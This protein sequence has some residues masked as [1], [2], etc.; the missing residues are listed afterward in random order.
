MKKTKNNI[1]KKSLTTKKAFKFR[2]NLTKEQEN[3]L[4]E[5]IYRC[6]K[7][8]NKGINKITSNYQIAKQ[9]Y[10][11]QIISLYT[12]R[13]GNWY[14]IFSDSSIIKKSIKVK[15]WQPLIIKD[16]SNIQSYFNYQSIIPPF[17]QTPESIELRKNND[18]K[19]LKYKEDLTIKYP[20]IPSEFYPNG[21]PLR[22]GKIKSVEKGGNNLPM[23]RL[24]QNERETNKVIHINLPAICCTYQNNIKET[25]PAIVFQEVIDK[26]IKSAFE[27]FWKGNG[28]YPTYKK[29]SLY[30]SATW[31]RIINFDIENGQ[32]KLQMFPGLIQILRTNKFKKFKLSNRYQEMIKGKLKQAILSYDNLHQYYVSLLYE[33]PQIDIKLPEK[34]NNVLGIDMNIKI[35]NHSFQSFITCHDGNKTWDEDIP[36]WT[37]QY[38]KEIAKISIK[39]DIYQ[40]GSS[41]WLKYNQRIQHL[42]E[43]K[44]NKYDNWLHNLSTNLSTKYDY[45]CM[46]DMDLTKFHEKNDELDK[47]N[48]EF[49]KERN[50]RKAWNGAP[51]GEL[52]RQFTYKLKERFILVPSYY[53]TQKCYNCKHINK[54]VT[55]NVQGKW[56]C[57]QCGIEHDRQENAAKNI[58]N[59]GIVV[60]KKL[61]NKNI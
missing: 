1:N 49:C 6:W 44:S 10:N 37:A 46:E 22:F 5:T 60:I 47:T 23:Y 17:N 32:L 31:T 61:L 43:K 13:I 57:E 18:K 33:Y 14:N 58:R 30:K 45:I 20:P 53:T 21:T 40:C 2:I 8:K 3:Y 42:Y 41:N 26:R 16:N 50:I 29:K 54:H 59:D 35:K 51:F 48:G 38:E 39:R 27:S 11:S 4:D 52:K 9:N 28:E 15:I 34:I 56:I 19:I 36:R 25:I 12:T 24:V 55:I 7:F